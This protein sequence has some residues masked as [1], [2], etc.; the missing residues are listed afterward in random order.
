MT[1]TTR[2]RLVRIKRPLWFVLLALGI[3]IVA[4]AAILGFARYHFGGMFPLMAL[5]IGLSGGVF[6]W[7]LMD[8]FDKQASWPAA[9]AAALMILAIY[10]GHRYIDYLLVQNSLNF[11]L[12]FWDYLMISAGF[13]HTLGRTG[14]TSIF[15]TGAWLGWGLWTLELLLA[16][17][18]GGALAKYMDVD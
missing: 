18:M 10:A 13:D 5:L 1:K 9:I 12:A 3:G 15:G 2:K 7:V 4:I 8:E 6:G 11:Y 17:G 16:L 14:R